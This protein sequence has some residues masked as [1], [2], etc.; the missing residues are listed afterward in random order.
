MVQ[1]AAALVFLL[2]MDAVASQSCADLDADVLILGAG[3]AGIAAAKRLND[4]GITNTVILEAQDRIGGR[5]RRDKLGGVTIELGANWIQGIDPVEPERHPLW[6]L[7]QKCGGLEGSYQGPEAI[8]VYD[9]QGNDI[10]NTSHLRYDDYDASFTAAIE[11][12]YNRSAAGRTDISA[13]QGLTMVGWTPV[14]PVDNYVEWSNFDFCYAISP[15]IASLNRSEPLTYELY[16]DPDRTEDYFVHDP[17]GFEKIVKCLAN[18]FLQPGDEDEQSRLHLNATVSEIEWGDECVCATATENGKER[19]YC[20]PYAIITFS[21]GVLQSDESNVSFVP[22]LPASKL[23]VIN[24]FCM[25]HYLKLFVEFNE[26]FWDDVACIGYVDDVRGYFPTIQPLNIYPGYRNANIVFLT[27]TD[28]IA[29]RIVRQSKEETKAEVKQILQNVYGPSVPDPINIILP[30]W[31]INPLFLGAY[32]AIQ[33]GNESS[34]STLFERLAA[35]VGRLYFSGEATNRNYGF[36][37]SGLFSGYDSADAVIKAKSSAGYN[38]IM[39]GAVVGGVG[40]IIA[41]ILALCI[42][43]NIRRK[44]QSKTR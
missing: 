28:D 31:D 10:T 23:D 26:S 25:A 12:S 7:A 34:N 5:M 14:T 16:G 8:I 2:L 1:F 38:I 35:P 21:I 36:V 29:T 33:V 32:S 27:V 15:D 17:D 9:K 24:Q 39:V 22:D 13:R 4:A 11:I 3:I 19:K 40:V 44:H 43:Y 42:I 41:V 18:D 30:D 37:H 6:E 20:A